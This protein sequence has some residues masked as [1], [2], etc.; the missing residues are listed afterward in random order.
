[1]SLA[2]LLMGWNLANASTCLPHRLQYP[3]GQRTDSS[4]PGGLA[5]LYPAWMRRAAPLA[6]TPFSC[7]AS[8]LGAASHLDAPDAVA[9]WMHSIGMARHLH[10][11]GLSSTDIPALTAA[12]R[13]NLATDPCDHS[14]DALAAIYSESL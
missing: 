8:L 12:V 9:S 13:G 5:A 2:S 1:M 7:I 14:P 10:Q 3:V 11:F 6:P 4:H